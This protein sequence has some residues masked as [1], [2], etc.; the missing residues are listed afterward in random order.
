MPVLNCG[1]LRQSDEI[2]FVE[3]EKNNYFGIGAVIRL[4]LLENYY[5][6]NDTL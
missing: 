1:G 2:G 4:R 3:I 5:K 6:I